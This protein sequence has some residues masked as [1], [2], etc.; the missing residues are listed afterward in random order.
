MRRWW[1]DGGCGGR[2]DR[3]GHLP[4]GC[5]ATRGRLMPSPLCVYVCVVVP[6]SRV[7]L[8]RVSASDVPPG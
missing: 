6:L 7:R 4:A 3:G 8:S 5:G 2:G 1:I